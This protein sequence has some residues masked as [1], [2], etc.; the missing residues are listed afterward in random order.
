MAEGGFDSENNLQRAAQ[1][2]QTYI[3]YLDP[4]TLISRT[5][6]SLNSNNDGYF[7]HYL[8]PLI[9]LPQRNLRSSE[10]LLRKSFEFFFNSVAIYL[11]DYPEDKQGKEIASL[12]EQVCD[13]LFFTVITV[14]DELNAYRVF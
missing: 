11:K 8:V 2:R 9:H 1:L 7:K 3:G 14:N 10:R 5:K 13:R 6:L 4:V 12:V